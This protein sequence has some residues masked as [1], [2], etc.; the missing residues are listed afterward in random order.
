MS[1]EVE[2][3]KAGKCCSGKNYDLAFLGLAVISL[4]LFL[5]SFILALSSGADHLTLVILFSIAFI[6]AAVCFA[7]FLIKAKSERSYLN[8]MLVIS[9]FALS[10]FGVLLVVPVI[11]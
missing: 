7:N 9:A 11:A 10:I 5:V 2:A 8:H 6:L 3:K 4:V 1:E